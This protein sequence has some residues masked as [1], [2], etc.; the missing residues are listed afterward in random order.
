[1]R[2]SETDQIKNRRCTTS[3]DRECCR[4]AVK[5]VNKKSTAQVHKEYLAQQMINHHKKEYKPCLFV[6]C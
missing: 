6:F 2:T 3:S 5:K 1:M 4:E